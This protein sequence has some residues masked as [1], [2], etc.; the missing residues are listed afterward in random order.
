M[1]RQ[2]FMII[3]SLNAANDAFVNSHSLGQFFLRDAAQC[4]IVCNF[5]PDLTED[6]FPLNAHILTSHYGQFLFY[7]QLSYIAFQPLYIALIRRL[8]SVWG[9]INAF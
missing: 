7:I 4:T 8:I 5:S 6:N 9:N 1:Q 2:I 3:A